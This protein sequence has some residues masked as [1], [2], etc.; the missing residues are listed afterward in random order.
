MNDRE[1]P[2]E[3]FDPD[4]AGRAPFGDTERIA[5]TE[6]FGTAQ[7]PQAGSA[8][9]Q[10]TEAYAPTARMP[11]PPLGAPT[12]YDTGA[13]TI[14]FDPVMPPPNDRATQAYGRPAAPPAVVPPPRQRLPHPRVREVREVRA[15]GRFRTLGVTGWVRL[16]IAVPVLLIGTLLAMSA[17][18]SA[19]AAGDPG[20]QWGVLGVV[21]LGI[22]FIGW[23]VL[24]GSVGGHFGGIALALVTH[25]TVSL[26]VW[27]APSTPVGQVIDEGTRGV[28][29]AV[30]L[31][32]IALVALAGAW[33]TTRG[34][35]ARVG[36]TLLIP[37]AFALFTAIAIPGG[38]L[39]GTLPDWWNTWITGLGEGLHPVFAWS[40][41]LDAFL[42][43]GTD[44]AAR[45]IVPILPVIIIAAPFRKRH[46]Q[47][48]AAP[49]HAQYV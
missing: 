10:S 34:K 42:T 19:A 17:L 47:T 23:I 25:A 48:I 15:P 38:W 11:E 6:Q 16:L 39:A 43:Q 4:A 24:P 36:L 40:G 41:E 35:P 26:A 20:A 22:L 32:V 37:L 30:I 18:A 21:A 28:F 8:S 27:F 9:A 2:T 31:P 12:A 29:N 7:L 45:L 3:P 5:P 46:P 1:H 33:L 14:A 13:H 44:L 49:A